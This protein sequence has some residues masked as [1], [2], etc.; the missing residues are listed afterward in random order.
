MKQ[1]ASTLDR[2]RVRTEDS[3]T[4]T[5]ST[6]NTKDP[7]NDRNEYLMAPPVKDILPKNSPLTLPANMRNIEQSVMAAAKSH[8][9][10]FS[11][12][13][14]IEGDKIVCDMTVDFHT[15]KGPNIRRHVD[16]A[17]PEFQEIAGKQNVKQ[18][19]WAALLYIKISEFF[20]KR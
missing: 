12:T 18:N 6:V 14:S 20:S 3:D 13:I 1:Q 19:P 15:L 4:S 16:R 9:A 7:S 2:R 11:E 8:G 5:Q 17:L 10:S